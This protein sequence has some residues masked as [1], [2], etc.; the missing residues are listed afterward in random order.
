MFSR[1]VLRSALPSSRCNAAV[2]LKARAASPLTSASRSSTSIPN[3]FSL[4]GRRYI[5]VYGY[6]QAKA[7]VYSKYG[8]PKDVLKYAGNNPPPPPLIPYHQEWVGA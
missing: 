6:T 1:G 8:E 7:L 5:S 4:A 3:A 2:A